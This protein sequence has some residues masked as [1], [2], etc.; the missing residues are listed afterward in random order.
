MLAFSVA[1]G[2]TQHSLTR[3]EKAPVT[4]AISIS[5]VDVSLPSPTAEFL[6][7]V[8]RTRILFTGDIN[9]GRCIADR[10]L[11]DF[12]YTNNFHYP[13][14]FVADE[15]RAADIT[16]G[17]L[18]GSLSDVSPPMPCPVSMNLI[19]P[20]RM[21]EGLQFAGFD[22]MTLATNHVKDCGRKGYECDNKAM[23]D[24]MDTL[25]NLDIQPVGA[26]RSL[27]EAR[28]P[29]VV[30]RNGIRFAFLAV[31][32]IEERVWAAENTPGTAPLSLEYIEQI[33]AD[34]SAAKQIADVVILLPQW[35]VEYAAQP[36]DVQR[37]WAR[38]F[39]S[40]GASLVVGNHP[41]II[42]PT[43]S[44][45]DGLI[46]YALG[47]FV[48]DQEQDFRRESI[49]VEVNF[50]GTEIESWNLRAASINYYTFQTSWAEDVEAQSI[51][52]RAKP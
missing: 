31:N 6:T 17:S 43:E 18:D 41:H 45:S 28:A 13:F 19:A 32:Q 36:D 30:T 9:L 48:F 34:I 22:V 2:L 47:N 35:G 46:F 38:D 8:P 50:L 42:Q 25:S 49:V 37:V 7:P 12:T 1:F 20:T 4:P 23:F 5:S 21:A 44:F 26:G 27:S 16:V 14:Q 11:R 3:N 51:L 33:K 40:A 29:V 15:L 52:A 24:T 10:T 39:I